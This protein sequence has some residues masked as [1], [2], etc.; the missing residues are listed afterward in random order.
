MRGRNHRAIA[1]G[2]VIVAAAASGCGPSMSDSED[3]EFGL[4]DPVFVV[5]SGEIAPEV[6]EF[7]GPRED[8][9]GSRIL[10]VDK[11]RA[12][13]ILSEPELETLSGYLHE[14]LN[15]CG[16]FTSHATLESART[17]LA[18]EREGPEGALAS[19]PLEL[20]EPE[21]VSQLIPLVDAGQI[22]ATITS[23]SAFPT[24]HYQSASGVDAANF[25]RDEWAALAASRPGAVAELRPHA[26]WAQP[27]VMLTIP[28]DELPDEVVVV[29]GHLDS[30]SFGGSAPG[31]DDDA[32][33]IATLTEIARLIVSQDVRLRRTVIFM[34]YAAE[35]VGLRGSDEIARDFAAQGTQVAGVLHFDM[36][37]FDGSAHDIVFITDN[38]DDAQTDFLADLSATYVPEFP[39][40]SDACG[41]ACSDHASWS[42]AGFAAVFPFEA[43]MDT[44]NPN[45]HTSGD[46]L[47]VS[48]GNADH[49]AKFA[50]LGV[51]YVVETAEVPD[52]GTEP[53]INP[54]V[55]LS[56]VAYDVPG[57]DRLGEFV[58]LANAGEQP[59][60]L[61]GFS[62]SSGASSF[63]FPAGTTVPAGGFVSVASDAAGFTSLYGSTADVAGARLNLS[64]SAGELRLLDP[65]GEEV[66]YV[67]WE[68][69]GWPLRASTGQSIVRTATED[70]GT[71][72]DWGVTS[73]VD[74]R[75]G[76]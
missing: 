13:L 42:R 14:K 43:T 26:G 36:T 19:P 28:G 34:G 54:T 39:T 66:D 52:G 15:R 4:Q 41:Y 51:A 45:I 76:Q 20:A 70:T 2:L 7:L 6:G 55:Q 67:G 74:P 62:L 72:A 24:R 50:K 68:R 61:G 33:G 30:I 73:S 57:L 65:D 69:S 64:N 31:A 38:T 8:D 44:Y 29:G 1:L 71:A 53:P 59:A 63:T 58:D 23:L 16:G 12:I 35:E 75:G 22:L 10:S 40:S 11:E 5:M 48:G 9:G 21:V 47:S 27:S 37:N 32:S 56:Q 60:D 3:S 46:T 18:G 49:A 17:A 25:L